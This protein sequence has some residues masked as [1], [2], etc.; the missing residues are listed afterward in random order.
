MGIPYHLR[1]KATVYGMA[2]HILSRKVKAKQTLSKRKIMATM[3][4]DRCCVFLVHFMPHGTTMNSDAYR[5]TQRKLRR[6]FQNKRL[7]MLS[8]G[9][10][11][12]YDNA[13]HDI[14]RMTRELIESFE[15]EV[16]DHASYSPDLTLRDFIFSCT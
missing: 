13:R 4:W 2:R 15:W 6:A 12:L 11:L 3:F 16:L 7:G 9:V 14:S 8:K 1:I 5:A 10:L